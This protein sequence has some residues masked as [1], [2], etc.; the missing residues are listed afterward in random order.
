MKN[1]IC[2][3]KPLDLAAILIETSDLIDF[4]ST[5]DAEMGNRLNRVVRGCLEADINPVECEYCVWLT[6]QNSFVFL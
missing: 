4:I 1:S 5:G 2:Q 6:F 3:L